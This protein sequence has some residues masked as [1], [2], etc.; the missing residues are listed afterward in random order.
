MNRWGSLILLSWV[1]WAL[2]FIPVSPVGAK[3]V[4]SDIVR[5]ALVI[6]HNQGWKGE[7]PLRFATRDALRMATVLKQRG[8]FAQVFLKLNPSKQ[9][10]EQ[11]FETIHKRTKSL[12]KKKKLHFLFYYSGH[13]DQKY[14]HL[15]KKSRR[16][17]KR[18][19]ISKL[20]KLLKKIKA[21]VKIIIVDSC[22][23][24]VFLY[25]FKGRGTGFKRSFPISLQVAKGLAILTSTSSVGRAREDEALKAS[26]FSHYLIRGLYGNADKNNDG[27]VTIEE[28]FRYARNQV[29]SHLGESQPP[30]YRKNL[31]QEKLY[32]LSLPTQAQIILPIQSGD[33]Y[34]I[35]AKASQ[36]ILE[37]N[38]THGSK[39]WVTPGTYTVHLQDRKKVC[40]KTVVK[41]VSRKVSKISRKRLQKSSCQGFV[42]WKGEEDKNAF[43]LLSLGVTSG[44]VT[45]SPIPPWLGGEFAVIW[46]D[47]RFFFNFQAARTE[48]IFASFFELA[49]T[50]GWSMKRARWNLHL[51]P[52]G[53][54]GLLS[55][56]SDRSEL[57]GNSTTF[58]LGGRVAFHYRVLRSIWVGVKGFG[59]FLL[60]SNLPSQL[61]FCF[62]LTFSYQILKIGDDPSIEIVYPV[63]LI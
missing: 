3:T 21:A 33:L 56:S 32:P 18:F 19:T 15:G 17:G 54:I 46:E 11:I 59:N 49:I 27:N 10:I 2:L 28:A 16:K 34:K 25:R 8:L 23:S 12:Y 24:G 14:L 45:G 57:T 43:H 62:N 51:G 4:A 31:G 48:P 61:H 39:T 52:L 35:K 41:A 6:G 63:P 42:R 5:V 58:R 60:P 40:Y 53:G 55:T 1:S 50:W 20:I 44:L 36:E 30:H 7:D 29:R 37:K 9:N 47:L 26:V 38:A 13:A 22:Y